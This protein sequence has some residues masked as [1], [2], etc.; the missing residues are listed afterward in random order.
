M[1]TFSM[2]V[3]PTDLSDQSQAALAHAAQIARW[4]GARLSVLHV[5]DAAPEHRPSLSEAAALPSRALAAADADPLAVVREHVAGTL[6][7][8][9]FDV[10]VLS[11]KA[12]PRIVEHAE[13]VGADLIVMSTHGRSGFDRLVHGSVT[14]R[15][16]AH[17][18]CPVLTVPPHATSDPQ[19]LFRK[20][21]CPVDFSPSARQA[22]DIALDL[23]RQANGTLRVLHAIEWYPEGEMIAAGRLDLDGFRESLK[24]Q[25]ST[26]LAGLLEHVDT[27][28]V[29]V[30]GVVA[31][32][33]PHR[34]I[35]EDA[36]AEGADLIVMGAQ[37]TEGLDL[38]VFGSTTRQVLAQASAPVLVTRG[39]R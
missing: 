2:L 8:V 5:V 39:A 24:D 20:V 29:D 1:I 4:Y 38:A 9:A 10:T 37:G 19:A 7:G 15:V 22:F 36:D 13:A 23:A 16:L 14:E 34:R 32:G 28:W 3:C 35:L 25:A 21:L 18:P 11:G 27:S 26:R 33:R 31:V 17:A 30:Q 6:A 12:A